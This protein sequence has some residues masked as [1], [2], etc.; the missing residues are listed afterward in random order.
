MTNFS[1][2]LTSPTRKYVAVVDWG[3][4]GCECVEFTLPK[5]QTNDV[6]NASWYYLNRIDQQGMLLFTMS[7]EVYYS[8]K[9][10]DI[11]PLT[12]QIT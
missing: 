5:D 6:N 9:K 1:K 8:N 10:F 7:Q 3:G 11:S 12:K 2:K 4:P